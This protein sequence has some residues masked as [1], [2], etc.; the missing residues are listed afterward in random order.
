[1]PE[2]EDVAEVMD[3]PE[4]EEVPIEVSEEDSE[5][6]EVSDI[7]ISSVRAFSLSIPV[8]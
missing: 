5:V 4:I 8:L 2:Q 6:E 7:L 3:V 1:M